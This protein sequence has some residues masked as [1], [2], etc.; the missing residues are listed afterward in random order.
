MLFRNQQRRV[1]PVGLLI[2]AAVAATAC[3]PAT[4]SAT[5]LLTTKLRAAKKAKRTCSDDVYT[6]RRGVAIRRVRAADTG[7]VQAR[8]VRRGRTDW[9]LAV[10]DQRDRLVAASSA[11]ATKESAEGLDHKGVSRHRPSPV[12]RRRRLGRPC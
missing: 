10:F 7:L 9:D 4:A 8:L 6:Q 11:W 1:A 5:D 2:C 12:S 3:V